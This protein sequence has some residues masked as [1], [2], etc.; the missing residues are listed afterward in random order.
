MAVYLLTWNPEQYD[1]LTS[2]DEV[3]ERGET[4]DE[5]RTQNRRIVAGDVLVLLRQGAEPRGIVGVGRATGT[6]DRFASPYDGHVRWYVPLAWWYLTPDRPLVTL[7]ELRERFPIAH[8][9]GP[10]GSGTLLP[11]PVGPALCDLLLDRTER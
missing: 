1:L 6:P 5:W 8:G 3:A 9:W 4:A 10:R 7:A 2:A 11:E